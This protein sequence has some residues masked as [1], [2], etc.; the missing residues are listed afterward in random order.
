MVINLAFF[1]KLRQVSYQELFLNDYITRD[2]SQDFLLLKFV[3]R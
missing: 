3:F 1:S 2:D